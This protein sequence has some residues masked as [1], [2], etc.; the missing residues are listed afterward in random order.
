MLIRQQLTVG[1]PFKDTSGPSMNILIKL[2]CLIG[3][4]I[5]PILGGHTDESAM[6]MVENGKEVRVE[7]N[8]EDTNNAK[9][10]VTTTTTKN[11]IAQVNEQVIEGTVED[12]KAEVEALKDVDAEVNITKEKIIKEVEQVV[13]EN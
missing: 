3:L 5:A 9:A 11:G 4:V 12:V 13:K 7:M 6:A 10:V 1:D 2:T 8:A